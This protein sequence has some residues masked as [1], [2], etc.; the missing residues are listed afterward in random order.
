MDKN[1]KLDKYEDWRLTN[2][3]RAK[4]LLSKMSLEEKIGLMLI[5]TTRL[6]NEGR[7]SVI[8]KQAVNHQ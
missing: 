4:D 8:E 6:K 7:G 1:G 5:S 3:E 2:E